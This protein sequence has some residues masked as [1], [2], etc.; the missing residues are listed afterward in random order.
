MTPDQPLAALVGAELKVPLVQGGTARYANL[1]LAASAPALQAV[2]DRLAEVLPYY[3]GVHRGTGYASAVS[4]ALYEG[5]RAAVKRFVSARCTD[6]VVFTRNTTDSLNMLATCVPE[7]GE[8]VILDIEHHANLLPWQRRAHRVLR[9]GETPA[10][11]LSLLDEELS[12]RPAAL[13]AVTGATNVTGELLPVAAL[14]ELCHR[15][16]ARIVVDAAQLAPHRRLDM[17]ASDIDYLTFSGHKVYAPYGSGVLIGRSDWLDDAPPY[18]AGGGAVRQVRLEHTEWA[19]APQR[20]EAGSP[21]VLGAVALGTA[22]DI[23]S[24]LFGGPLERHETRLRDHL[25]AGLERLPGIT[26][27]RIWPGRAQS[28][29]VVSFSV[30]GHDSGRIAAYLAAEHGIGVRDG[31]FCAHPLAERLGLPASGAVRA[32]FGLGSTVEEADRLLAALEQWLTTGPTWNYA[33]AEGRWAPSPD[34]RPMPAWVPAGS[35]AV[36]AASPCAP[37]PE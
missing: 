6:T 26:V 32:S 8:V 1:D 2:A 11:T 28:I 35:S 14:T 15:H 16:G 33:L 9:V 22:C 31:K 21:N 24:G 10:E 13:V 29:G 17:T 19:P 25:T 30:E 3:S 27:H 18:L 5:A 4:T 20:H 12:G 23:L 36:P 34:T 37:D 7:G